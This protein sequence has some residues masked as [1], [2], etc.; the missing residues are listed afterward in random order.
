MP[1][2][3]EMQS[4]FDTYLLEL[5]RWKYSLSAE[6]KVDRPAKN[7]LPHAYILN[8]VYHTSI[9]LLCKPFLPRQKQHCASEP[10]NYGDKTTQ[11]AILLCAES[12]KEIATLSQQYRS[13]FGGFRRSPITATHCSLSAA[14]VSVQVYHLGHTQSQI[15]TKHLLETFSKTLEELSDSW[16]PARR[17]WNSVRQIDQGLGRAGVGGTDIVRSVGSDLQAARDISENQDMTQ[18]GNQGL[19]EEHGFT[20]WVGQSGQTDFH[21]D[22]SDF[23]ELLSLGSAFENSSEGYLM[24]FLLDCQPEFSYI[25]AQD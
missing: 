22:G 18:L 25:P 24:P 12:A 7:T 21:V 2:A 14:L 3:A 15:S 23:T 19:V 20:N 10:Y 5:K 4:L 8:M 9:I 11:T 6:L 13:A 16:L 17:Y 1:S